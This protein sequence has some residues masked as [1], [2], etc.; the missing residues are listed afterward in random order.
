MI[1]RSLSRL[2]VAKTAAVASFGFALF[3]I[4]STPY[5]DLVLCL[6]IAFKW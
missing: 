5:H 1:V 6:L 3:V 2:K 4:A